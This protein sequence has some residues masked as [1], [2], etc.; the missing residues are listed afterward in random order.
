[1]YTTDVHTLISGTCEYVILQGRMD[2]ADVIKVYRLEDGEVIL[3][4]PGGPNLITWVLK[5]EESFLAAVREKCDNGRRV[6]WCDVRRTQLTIAGFEDGRK[7]CEPR[8]VDSLSKLEKARI[9]SPPESLERN[10][11]LPAPWF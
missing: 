11:A 3:V 8:N 7:D 1:M 9:H 4:N 5:C 6:K 2:F 10:E